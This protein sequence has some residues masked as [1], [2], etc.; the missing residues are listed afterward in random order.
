[1]KLVD[2]K[3]H[4]LMDKLNHNSFMRRTQSDIIINKLAEEVCKHSNLTV[5]I[6]ETTTSKIEEHLDKHG[7]NIESITQTKLSRTASTEDFK[8]R[9]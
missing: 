4:V 1:M 8:G 5:G 3:P 2:M 6:L 7:N 9:R